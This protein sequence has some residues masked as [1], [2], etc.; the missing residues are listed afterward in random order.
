MPSASPLPDLGRFHLTAIDYKK[1]QP[2]SGTEPTTL[3]HQGSGF[4]Y[5]LST[6]LGK[7]CD[8]KITI[9][10]I[11][12]YTFSIEYDGSKESAGIGTTIQNGKFAF[13]DKQFIAIQPNS[14]AA[15]KVFFTSAG[16]SNL[17][18]SANLGAGHN[19]YVTAENKNET[20]KNIDRGGFGLCM[21]AGPIRYEKSLKITMSN[22]SEWPYVNL[23]WMSTVE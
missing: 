9:D 16:I 23:Y 8:F 11:D 5:G 2:A 14:A 4:F 22:F 13:I 17:Y 3:I 18:G 19:F 7:G 1:T 21:L 15:D 12:V 10:D 20:I 6:N